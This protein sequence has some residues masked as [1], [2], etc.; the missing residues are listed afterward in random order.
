MTITVDDV[1][2]LKSQR[3]TDEDDGGGRATGQAVVDREIHNLFPDI[4]RL[5]RTIGRINLRK[6]FAGISSN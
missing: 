3:L 1:K 2:L 6:A 5:D 4:S